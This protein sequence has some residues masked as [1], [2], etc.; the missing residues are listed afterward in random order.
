MAPTLLNY[1][2]VE[3]VSHKLYT[4]KPKK[5]C[6]Y[7]VGGLVHISKLKK[8]FEK[9]YS[10][11]W[12][13]ALFQTSHIYRCTLPEYTLADLDDE[14]ITGKFMEPELQRVSK[15]KSIFHVEKVLLSKGKGK[16]KEAIVKFIDYPEVF[17]SWLPNKDVCR[18]P[19]L[20][21]VWSEISKTGRGLPCTDCYHI[22][23]DFS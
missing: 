22:Y 15:E 7:K 11:K 17:N 10:H 16:N 19:L 18:N 9:G 6:K 23:C 21:V 8:T 13:T 12:T 2:N 4:F 3:D 20:A 5:N 1:K 14:D